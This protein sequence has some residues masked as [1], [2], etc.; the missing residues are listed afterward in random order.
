M[1][2]GQKSGKDE[3]PEG[4]WCVGRIESRSVRLGQDNIRWEMCVGQM[5]KGLIF[6]EEEFGFFLDFYFKS[7]MKLR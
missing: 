4:G 2:F 5:R 6:Q 7:V 1:F 3:A